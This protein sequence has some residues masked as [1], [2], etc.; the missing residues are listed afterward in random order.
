MGGPG[1]GDADFRAACG[2]SADVSA[3]LDRT[4]LFDSV[5][6]RPMSA[7]RRP[8]SG[9]RRARLVR[10]SLERGRVSRLRP[11]RLSVP[12]RR[13]RGR[14][15]GLRHHVV[16]RRRSA[17]PEHLHSQRPAQ[18]AASV[19]A[20][21]TSCSSGA[22]AATCRMFSS[23]CGRRTRRDSSLRIARL[24]AR[25]PAQGLLPGERRARR[26]AGLQVVSRSARPDR[27]PSVRSV[28][29]LPCSPLHA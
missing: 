11:R 3:E 13:V 4:K 16:R 20:S 15:R 18:R 29:D 23:K 14:G 9:R 28:L 26:R 2:R 25:R 10:V 12:R 19:A 21:W 8:G 22:R 17:H 24:R 5:R 1:A 27:S 6:F 7:G